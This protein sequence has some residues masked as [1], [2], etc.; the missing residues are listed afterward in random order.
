MARPETEDDEPRYGRRLSPEELADYLREQ[1]GEPPEERGRAAPGEGD[2]PDPYLRTPQEDA[3]PPAVPA[4]C[5]Y[6]PRRADRSAAGRPSPVATAASPSSSRSVVPGS[7]AD[8]AGARRPWRLPTIGL[9][10]MLVVPM[11]LVVGA[12]LIAF[13]GFRG[14]GAA[15]GEAGTVYLERGTTSVLYSS[16]AATTSECT[17]TG[18]DGSAVTLTP[19]SED[20]PYASF[21]AP[22]TG[23]FTVS[24]PGGTADVI[25]GPPVSVSRLPLSVALL[26]AAGLIGAAGLVMTTIGAVRLLP[27]PVRGSA[28]PPSP[29]R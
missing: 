10:L 14:P 23:V 24:C 19:L 2:G 12:V 26:L 8:S 7:S 20:M 21:E 17:V 11:V 1:D 27:R 22:G 25:I 3:V 29:R 6:S 18:P 16:A 28:V 9:I 15:L 4:S 5:A 13:E